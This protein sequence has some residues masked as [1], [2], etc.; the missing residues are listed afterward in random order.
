M[1]F[2][3]RVLGRAANVELTIFD[4]DGVLTDGRLVLGPNGQEF[5]NFHVRD[6]LGL[7]MLR[8]SGV[9]VAIITGRKSPVVAERM[10]ELGI[11]LVFQGQSNKLVAFE[12]LLS[13]LNIDPGAVCYVG[14]DLP[15]IPVMRRAGLPITVADADRRVSEYAVYQTEAKGGRGAAREVCELIMAAKGSLDAQLAR[16]DMAVHPNQ[17]SA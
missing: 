13:S 1:P 4:V 14:D 17:P 8:E 2:E 5:K 12:T 9:A 10:A 6:G 15:D 11:D 16:F 7:V 3:A